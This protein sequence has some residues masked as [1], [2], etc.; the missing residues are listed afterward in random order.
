MEEKVVLNILNG[1]M[2]YDYV[3]QSHLDEDGI[4]VP[5]NEAICSGRVTEQIFSREFNKCR[6]NIHNISMDEY[7]EI[8]LKP[9]RPLFENEFSSIVLWFDE[10]MFCQINLLTILAYL[11]QNSYGSRVAFNLVGRDFKLIHGFEFYAQGY[12]QI[13]KQVML[14]RSMP[15]SI[16]LGTLKKGVELYLEYL[17]KDNVITEYIKQHGDLE[18]SILISNLLNKFSQYGLTDTQYLK[19]IKECRK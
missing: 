3:R 5:F 6:C 9:L 8:T 18:E 15:E 17:K 1:Q 19:L 4:Y 12:L 10:D 11:D 14:C 13:Y 7:N 16:Y 2:M